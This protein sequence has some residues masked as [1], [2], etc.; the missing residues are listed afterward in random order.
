MK[1]IGIS[2]CNCGKALDKHS[3]RDYADSLESFM[4]KKVKELHPKSRVKIPEFD[5]PVVRKDKKEVPVKVTIKGEEFIQ[6][7]MIK[8]SRCNL[9]EKEGTNY[10]E[11]VMQLRGDNHDLLQ[12][13]V[14][15]LQER[16]AG[17]RQR[18]LFVNKIDEFENGFDLYLTSNK[19]AQVIGREML[20]YY[21]GKLIVSPRLFSKNHQTSRELFRVNVL[22]ELPAFARGD[23]IIYKDRVWQAEKSARKIKLVDMQSGSSEYVDYDKLEYK[24]IPK[25][26]TYVSKTY[27]HMEVLNPNDYQSTMVKNK[28]RHAY[29]N[30]QGVSVVIHKGIYLVD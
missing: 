16:I 19:L 2:I 10:F 7:V 21:G 8:M 29:A 25:Q 27:P 17:L 30:G 11:A 26:K 20:D 3:W 22:V 23:F 14:N 15:Y 9:C 5:P 28:P 12:E 24:I 4:T 13:G 6:P 18:G 1:S